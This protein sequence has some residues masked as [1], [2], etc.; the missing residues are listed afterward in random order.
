MVYSESNNQMKNM[1]DFV[2]AGHLMNIQQVLTLTKQ[3]AKTIQEMH[4]LE[5]FFDVLEP[6]TVF[7]EDDQV[8]IYLIIFIC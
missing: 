5:F 3:L 1:H 7:V 8:R 4:S 6:N 2:Q